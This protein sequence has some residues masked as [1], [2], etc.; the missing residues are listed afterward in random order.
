[1]RT[2]KTGN[3][4]RIVAEAF[5]A[6]ISYAEASTSKNKEKIIKALQK[7]NEKMRKL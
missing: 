2:I 6:L 7:M 3:T 4:T 1:M 5:D